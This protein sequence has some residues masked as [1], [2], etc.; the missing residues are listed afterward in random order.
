MYKDKEEIKNELQQFDILFFSRFND[1]KKMVNKDKPEFVFSLPANLSQLGY[2]Y[3]STLASKEKYFLISLEEIGEG[4]KVKRVGS[5][6]L[7][8]RGH[9]QQYLSV[10]L[11]QKVKHKSVL[12]VEDLLSLLRFNMVEGIWVSERN[13]QGIQSKSK[14]N[15]VNN[16]QFI[17]LAAL[18]ILGTKNKNKLDEKHKIYMKFKRYLGANL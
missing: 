5:V 12:K 2:S 16:E 1:F 13:F 9:T 7:F 18:P 15:F 6:D 8:G 14:L 11:N 3:D 17:K 10:Q 4:E